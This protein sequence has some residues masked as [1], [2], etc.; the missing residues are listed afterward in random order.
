MRPAPFDHPNGEPPGPP[1]PLARSSHPE[2]RSLRGVHRARAQSRREHVTPCARKS[3]VANILG[4]CAGGGS[5]ARPSLVLD[6]WDS[7]SE[8]PSSPLTTSMNNL[9][10]TPTV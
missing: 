3:P 6:L 2:N 8:K 7:P 4:A 10:L 5:R 9:M 1:F